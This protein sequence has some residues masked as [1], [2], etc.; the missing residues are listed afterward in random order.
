MVCLIALTQWAKHHKQLPAQSVAMK[1]K[2]DTAQFQQ[3]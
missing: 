2:E 1:R 3:F